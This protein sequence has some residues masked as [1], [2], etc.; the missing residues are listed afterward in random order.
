M[1]FFFFC[2]FF[3]SFFFRPTPPCSQIKHTNTNPQAQTHNHG[4]GLVFFIALNGSG[5]LNKGF[6][7]LS[8][9][10]CL[11]GLDDDGVVGSVGWDFNLWVSVSFWVLW[12][13]WQS[14]K[15]NWKSEMLPFCLWLSV[16]FWV[17]WW[18]AMLPFC[19]IPVNSVLEPNTNC[20][21]IWIIVGLEIR[22][23]SYGLWAFQTPPKL[24]FL[25]N[26]ICIT[27]FYNCCLLQVQQDS[28]FL[29]K[30]GL[31]NSETNLL[32]WLMVSNSTKPLI[33]YP[34]FWLNIWAIL[35]YQR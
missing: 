20:R 28:T 11:L 27:G 9:V 14:R 23:L 31:S 4:W 1:V 30:R 12:W 35:S 15:M 10:N 18:V 25:Q 21:E 32:A 26:K 6:S 19:A 8:L 2:W 16:S 7:D 13:A 34:T 3:L 29:Y 17:L 5:L 33:S 22:V 24:L